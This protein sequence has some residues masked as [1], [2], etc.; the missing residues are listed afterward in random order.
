MAQGL[1]IHPCNSIESGFNPWWGTKT[2]NASEQL[3]LCHNHWSLC[4]TNR[5]SVCCQERSCMAQWRSQVPQL[6]QGCQINQ[7]LK[8]THSYFCITIT[9]THLFQFGILY[10]LSNNSSFSSPLTF[11][12]PPFYC[13]YLWF[14][15]LWVSH[16]SEI[17]LYLSFCNWLISFSIM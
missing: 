12:Q 8:K 5:E 11:S 3:S 14:W 17:I 7:L 2:P 4:A 1:R 6:R 9:T 16:I 13:L 10:S 15:L